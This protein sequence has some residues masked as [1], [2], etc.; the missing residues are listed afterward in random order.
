MNVYRFELRREWKNAAVW[1]AVLLVLLG[2]L[3]ISVYP[4]Y[5]DGR[6]EVLAA[7]QGF[8]PQFAAAFGLDIDTIFSFGGFYAFSF[9]YLAVLGAV[10]A[11]ALG[12][13]VFAREKRAKCDDFL[14]TKPRPRTALFAAKGLAALTLLVVQNLLYVVLFFVVCKATPQAEAPFGN[15]LVAAM[16]LLLTQLVFF[17]AGVCIAVFAKRVRSVSG[18]AMAVAFGGFLLTAL[19][20]IVKEEALRYLSP[21][22]YFDAALAFETGHF[23]TP[24]VVT[25]S[26][27]TAVLLAAAFVKY[28]TEQTHAV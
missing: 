2:V 22:Q 12:L 13:S 5:Y 27:L 15:Q 14:F 6:T 11:S 21:Y 23:E 24:M 4:I 9:L 3:L 18:M 17:A 8:P 1:T 16:A 10:F 7:L 19:Q 20:N 28:R 26:L 25:A